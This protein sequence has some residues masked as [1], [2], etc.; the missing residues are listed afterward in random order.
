ML[1]SSGTSWLDAQSHDRVDDVVVILLERLDGLLPRYVGLR[2]D[3]LNVLVLDALGVH[4]L[5]VILLLLGGLLGG[6]AT[7]NGLAGL[8]VV[9]ACV[10]VLGG[11]Q[12]LGGG[13]L[14]GGVQ[15]LDLGLTKDAVGNKKSEP[16]RGGMGCQKSAMQW[17]A[18]M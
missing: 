2:H 16:G 14:G 17:L 11:G 3:E 7:L 8:A 15:V 9:V 6:I 4:L 1:C 12:L 13:G 18:Y 5:T 10:V